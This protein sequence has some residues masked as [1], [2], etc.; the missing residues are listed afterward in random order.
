[1]T[2]RAVPCRAVPCRAVPCRAV[3]FDSTRA[4]DWT[5]SHAR[6]AHR[7]GRAVFHLGHQRHGA[8]DIETGERFNLIMWNKS[9]AFR[10]T[11]DFMS[12]YSK[13]PTE[14]NAPPDLVCLC[15]PPRPL[16]SA[17]SLTCVFSH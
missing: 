7:K 11:R 9:S 6:H 15:A 3:T 8:D 4:V 13:N 14:D 12:K 10:A 17:A 1:M 2:C 16:S 5:Y